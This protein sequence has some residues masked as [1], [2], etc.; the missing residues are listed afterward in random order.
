[1]NMFFSNWKTTIIRGEKELP[2]STL[3][4][5]SKNN[6][7]ELKYLLNYLKN[8]PLFKSESGQIIVI[9]YFSFDYSI[10]TV[11][12]FQSDFGN[13]IIVL[14]KN[15][16]KNI[17]QLIHPY[18]TDQ[19]VQFINL[20]SIESDDRHL[21]TSKLSTW[22]AALLRSFSKKKN[23]ID[24]K[25]IIQYMEK[26]REHL[27]EVMEKTAIEQLSNLQMVL[28][29]DGKDE[30]TI[31]ALRKISLKLQNVME[32]FDPTLYVKETLYSNMIGFV[33]DFTQRTQIEFIVKER[34]K[35]ITLEPLIGISVMRIVKQLFDFIERQVHCEKVVL[36]IRW[37]QNSLWI[38]VK[39]NN[40]EMSQQSLNRNFLHAIEERTALL[41]GKMKFDMKNKQGFSFLLTLPLEKRLRGEIN[42]EEK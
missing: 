11:S 6:K 19:F 5:V 39:G 31:D 32:H 16:G 41:N 18:I 1:M 34:G 15:E 22:Y 30:Q 38:Y 35:E 25:Q 7:E 27:F 17:S 2:K 4:I 14:Q 3:I 12:Q 24:M 13:D 20:A 10:E 33:E 23:S 37:K 21:P 40:I 42:D 28:K 29:E 36:T 26:E 8:M 9:D